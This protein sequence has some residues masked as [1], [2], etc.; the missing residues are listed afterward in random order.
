MVQSTGIIFQ[1]I[2]MKR[3]N[4][5]PRF[6]TAEGNTMSYVYLGQKVKT[7]QQINATVYIIKRIDS[8]NEMVYLVPLD[9]SYCGEWCSS[10]TLYNV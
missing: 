8:A 9:G 7:G 3:D 6:T 2:A 5:R 4:M 1:S 10:N